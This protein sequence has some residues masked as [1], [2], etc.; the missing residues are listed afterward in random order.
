VGARGRC[1]VRQ[2]VDIRSRAWLARLAPRELDGD[3]TG[4]GALVVQC[5]TP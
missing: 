2:V 4:A 3:L 1:S 5:T